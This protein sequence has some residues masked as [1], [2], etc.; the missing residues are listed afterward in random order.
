MTRGKRWLA[1]LLAALM[2][3]TALPAAALAA[4]APR[5]LTRGE[6]CEILLAAADDYHSGL[7][8]A[9]LLKGDGS[10]DRAEGLSLIHI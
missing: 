8:A 2:A 7:T 1:G 9:D 10:G 3:F 5:T 6:V 4:D